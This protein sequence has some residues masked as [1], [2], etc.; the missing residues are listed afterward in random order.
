MHKTFSPQPHRE[1][2][3]PLTRL[4]CSATGTKQPER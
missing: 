3:W 1:W 4:L 2:L